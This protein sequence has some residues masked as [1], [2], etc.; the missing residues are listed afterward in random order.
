MPHKSLADPASLRTSPGVASSSAAM[1]P[2][3]IN[4]TGTR[5]AINT[6]ENTSCEKVNPPFEADSAELG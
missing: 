6:I 2:L 1:A 4:D 3:S 5:D